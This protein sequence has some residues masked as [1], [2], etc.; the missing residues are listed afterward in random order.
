MY[1]AESYAG[2]SKPDKA[3]IAGIGLVQSIGIVVTEL[4]NDL[5][6]ALMIASSE[7]VTNELF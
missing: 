2:R 4:V 6:N 3:T 5:L 7:G 1:R